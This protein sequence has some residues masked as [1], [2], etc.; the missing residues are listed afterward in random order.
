MSSSKTAEREALTHWAEKI[1][2][3]SVLFKPF[4]IPL[5][6]SYDLLEQI[7]DLNIVP[8]AERNTIGIPLLS[9]HAHED[10]IHVLPLYL[11]FLSTRLHTLGTQQGDMPENIFDIKALARIHSIATATAKHH[12]GE[13]LWSLAKEEGLTQQVRTISNDHLI[14]IDSLNV[15]QTYD[16]QGWILLHSRRKANEMRGENSKGVR[17]FYELFRRD[18]NDPNKAQIVDISTLIGYCDEDVYHKPQHHVIPQIVE[19]MDEYHGWQAFEQIF[20]QIPDESLQEYY[21]QFRSAYQKWGE[22]DPFKDIPDTLRV[23]AKPEPGYREHLHAIIGLHSYL[24]R[25]TGL[26]IKEMDT[27]LLLGL[28]KAARLLERN[29]YVLPMINGFEARPLIADYID[30]F[31]NK[32][33][34]L[35]KEDSD[36]FN[37]IRFFLRSHNSAAT[38]TSTTETFRIVKET[39]FH[40]ILFSEA[41]CVSIEAEK[42]AERLKVRL[43]VLQAIWDY[44]KPRADEIAVHED[45]DKYATKR[46]LM[47]ILYFFSANKLINL[48]DPRIIELLDRVIVGVTDRD[49]WFIQL[50]ASSIAGDH[51]EDTLEMPKFV[52]HAGDTDEIQALLDGS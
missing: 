38:I 28:G 20:T 29:L 5:E 14:L 45:Q 40:K 16:Q 50:T 31:V 4:A 36:I 18:I 37:T 44:K 39:T 42:M 26:N 11:S 8:S 41:A 34:L 24:E 19:L 21:Q 30:E 3:N 2:R 1:P 17:D 47:A 12:I 7:Y 46:C 49:L 52:D 25:Q 51:I 22:F 48:R 6:Q 43:D 10:F 33:M 9:Q 15:K 27:K 23:L 32:Y 35:S 13:E